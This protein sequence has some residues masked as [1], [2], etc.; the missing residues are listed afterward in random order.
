MSVVGYAISGWKIFLSAHI[1]LNILVRHATEQLDLIEK[2]IE[3]ASAIIYG[4]WIHPDKI[5][6]ITVEEATFVTACLFSCTHSP[7]GNAAN[8]KRKKS[9]SKGANSF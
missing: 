6:A 2:K 4:K 3:L 9:A 7:P 5:S 8:Q 1:H